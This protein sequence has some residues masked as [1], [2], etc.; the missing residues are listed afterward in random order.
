MEDKNLQASQ[1]NHNE[2]L[3]FSVFQEKET[4]RG[5]PVKSRHRAGPDYL[6][7]AAQRTY[8]VKWEYSCFSCPIV[9]VFKA[10]NDVIF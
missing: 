4:K 3:K 9:H 7:Q 10:V 5:N 2:S 6:Q 1:Q 8:K